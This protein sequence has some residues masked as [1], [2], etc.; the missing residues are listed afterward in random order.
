MT[1]PFLQPKMKIKS[2]DFLSVVSS[3][4]DNKLL[5]KSNTLQ[6]VMVVFALGMY[7]DKITNLAKLFSDKDGNID[8]DK[9]AASAK[10]ALLKAGGKVNIPVLNYDFDQQD[11]TDLLDIAKGYGF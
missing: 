9:M 2:Q 5:P 8:L 4:I 7:K 3:W 1:S 11:L 10:D 6:T